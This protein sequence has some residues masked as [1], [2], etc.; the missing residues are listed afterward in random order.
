[1]GIYTYIPIHYKT[2]KSFQNCIVYECINQNSKLKTH[3]V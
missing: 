2:I 1:M 3:F